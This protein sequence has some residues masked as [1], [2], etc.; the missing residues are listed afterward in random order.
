[1]SKPRYG[2]DIE[3]QLVL[4]HFEAMKISLRYQASILVTLAVLALPQMAT[5]AECFADYKAKK[6][7]PLRLHYGVIQLYDGCQKPNARAEIAKRIQ[8]DG[9]TLLN[10]LSVFDG[11][12][13][14][15]KEASAGK[16]YLRY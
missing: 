3:Y 12:K 9:W 10:V 16:F 1:M 15:G 6:D 2:L 8:R 14:P 4:E 11:S 13:L 5:A 7:A